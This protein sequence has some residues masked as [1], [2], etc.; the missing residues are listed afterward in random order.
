[1]RQ[2]WRSIL[3]KQICQKRS[4]I[5]TLQSLTKAQSEP[6]QFSVSRKPRMKQIGL[7]PKLSLTL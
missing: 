3:A 1:M 4:C 5:I 6:A 7:T 2:L